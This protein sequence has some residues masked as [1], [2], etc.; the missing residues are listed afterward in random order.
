MAKEY[1]Q[2]RKGK[3][4]FVMLYEWMQNTEAWATMPPGPR[5]L[6]IELKRRYTGFNNGKIY[7]SHREAANACNAHRNTI[8]GW[9]QV[10]QDRGFIVQTRGPHLGPVGIG[11][12][13][14]WALT[15]VA[16]ADGKR[17]TMEFKK[18]KTPAQSPCIAVT[19]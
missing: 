18:W 8:G 2:A 13:A 3:P 16:T 7:L 11:M 5:M 12:A 10:L 4:P 15:E 6:Y 14:T 17:A 19:I 1:K 9:Y